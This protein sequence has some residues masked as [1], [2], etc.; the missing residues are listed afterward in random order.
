MLCHGAAT[1]GETLILPYY[2]YHGHNGLGDVYDAGIRAAE[3]LTEQFI[4]LLDGAKSDVNSEC[5]ALVANPIIWELMQR[6]L[7]PG[8]ALI[9]AAAELAF[10]SRIDGKLFLVWTSQHLMSWK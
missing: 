7:E 5:P 6:N 10:E 4:L 1:S 3:S 8:K 9:G 2:E